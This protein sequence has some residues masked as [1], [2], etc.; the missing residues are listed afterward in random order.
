M[1]NAKPY[2]RS[3]CGAEVPDLPMP[4]LKHQMSH[5]RRRPFAGDRREPDQHDHER[6]SG[7]A[8]DLERN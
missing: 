7:P 8:P 2:K 3:I 4:V 5:V 1:H 6:P